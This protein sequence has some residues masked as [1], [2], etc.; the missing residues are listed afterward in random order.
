MAGMHRR[1][2]R[3]VEPGGRVLAVDVDA[4]INAWLERKLAEEGVP[5][6]EMVLATPDDPGL[7]E[8]GVEL[9]FTAN[10]FHHLPTQGDY[11]AGV[12]K[13]LVPG[14]R[15]AIVEF[16]PAKAGWFARTFGHATPREEIVVARCAACHAAEPVWAGIV[17]APKGVM[18]DTPERIRMQRRAIALHAAWTA[19]MPP[20]N[21]TEMS[22]E[23][24]AALALWAAAAR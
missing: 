6:V 23:E 4:E 3:A 10:T 18:L 20:G 9:V 21:L 24:R 14:G 13:A 15:V 7:P 2:A 5:N 1:L 17:A 19:A 22:P 8:G 12:K 11:F 16:D